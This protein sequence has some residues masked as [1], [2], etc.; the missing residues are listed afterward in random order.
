VTEVHQGGLTIPADP[1]MTAATLTDMSKR[2][3]RAKANVRRKKANHGRK[4][5]LGRNS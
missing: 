5:N 4:P 3:S 1:T 2:T